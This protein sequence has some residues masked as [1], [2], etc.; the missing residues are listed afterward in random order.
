MLKF[1]EV[2]QSVPL[3]D[4][5]IVYSRKLESQNKSENGKFKVELMKMEMLAKM[6]TGEDLSL[7]EKFESTIGERDKSVDE[8]I[9]RQAG[10][11]IV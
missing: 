2:Y 8:G 4:A 10:F 3:G 1:R 7:V 9:I 6:I 11:E 5:L